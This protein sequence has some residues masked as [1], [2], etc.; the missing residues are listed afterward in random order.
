[1]KQPITPIYII[2]NIYGHIVLFIYLLSVTHLRMFFRQPQ[3]LTLGRTI[4]FKNFNSSMKN[5]EL[6]NTLYDILFFY[7]TGQQPFKSS[8][9]YNCASTEQ[10]THHRFAVREQGSS[11]S[12]V[13]RNTA[14]DPPSSNTTSQCSQGGKRNATIYIDDRVIE[15][16]ICII[17]HQA[18][19]IV[20]DNSIRQSYT[21]TMMSTCFRR[22]RYHES[23]RSSL[24]VTSSY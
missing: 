4:I 17:G 9:Q 1:M 6:I 7:Y 23:F 11:A 13:N 15:H 22:D 10:R 3:C 18:S 24:Y 12:T 20:V 14:T 8:S 19:Q 2:Y 5:Q 21:Y 16:V